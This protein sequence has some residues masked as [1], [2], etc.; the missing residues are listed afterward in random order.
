MKNLLDNNIRE[1]VTLH[2]PLIFFSFFFF[3]NKIENQ[4]IFLPFYPSHQTLIVILLSCP[5]LSSSFPFPSTGGH[6]FPSLNILKI[7]F[8]E[9]KYWTSW[10]GRKGKERRK[11]REE[12]GEGELRFQVE[13]EED[14]FILSHVV[15]I[16]KNEKEKIDRCKEIIGGCIYDIKWELFYLSPSYTHC[17]LNGI[18]KQNFHAVDHYSRILNLPLLTWLLPEPM[19]DCNL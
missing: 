5:S 11:K 17:Y 7:K 1:I 19:C 18:W 12:K 14:I 4:N 9:G 8:E 13:E 2:T 10:R 6:G 15:F 3:Q 16:W